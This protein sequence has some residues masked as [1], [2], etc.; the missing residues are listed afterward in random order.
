MQ[1]RTK[2]LLVA[3]VLLVACGTVAMAADATTIG[4]VASIL[5]ALVAG[6][7]GPWVVQPI[8]KLI[9]KVLPNAIGKKLMTWIAYAISFGAGIAVFAVTGGLP[10]ILA[11]PWSIFSAGGTVAGIA[12]AMYNMWKDSMELSR[13]VTV[14]SKSVVKVK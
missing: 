12:G 7:L 3:L 13:D 14:A 8:K 6:F 11:S 4:P 10:A 9:D 1:K 5:A 2:V